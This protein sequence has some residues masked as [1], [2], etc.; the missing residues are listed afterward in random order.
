[1]N[2]RLQ[3]HAAAAGRPAGSPFDPA[4]EAA[5][6]RWRDGKLQQRPADAAAITVDVADPRA[7]TS[8]ERRALGEAIARANVAIYR[9]PLRAEDPMLP[10]AL[11]A[12]LG[13]RR[14][15]ANGLAG[16]DGISRIEVGARTD[17]AAG[18]GG[19]IPYTCRGLRWH[20]DGY[21]HPRARRIH[22]MVLHAVRPAARGGINR[23]LDPELLYIALRDESPTL[24]RA[25]MRP[26]AMTIPARTGDEGI[27]RPAQSGP[28]FSVGRGALHLRY[29]ARTRSIEWH[30]D[31]EVQRAA[32]RL[33]ALL[34]HGLPGLLQVRLE[35]GM[36]LVGHNV[37]HDRSPFVDD[38]A[39]PRLLYRARFLD[40][41][42][43]D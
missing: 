25:L 36:G 11:G 2:A 18:R 42:A 6:A 41:V 26:D 23:L 35:A 7:P 39:R 8:A 37:L 5:Y 13:L 1:M 30:P 29:T 17:A 21:Y 28:V 20:T 9:S 3:L 27:A 14:L 10:L 33:A 40:R 19:F 38:P 4:N 22:G 32:A 34:E 24:I 31:A 16:E 43:P 15:D 12:A